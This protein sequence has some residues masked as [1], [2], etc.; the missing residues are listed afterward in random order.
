MVTNGQLL[1]A[2]LRRGPLPL[3]EAVARLMMVV[4]QMQD[5][6]GLLTDAARVQ[7]ERH[8]AQMGRLQQQIDRLKRVHGA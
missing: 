3:E 5:T 6:V 2:S 8:D 4:G 7:Q 1:V